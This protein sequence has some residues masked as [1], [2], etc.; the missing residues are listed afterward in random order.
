MRVNV[1]LI[2]DSSLK[3]IP[4]NRKLASAYLSGRM[5]GWFECRANKYQSLKYRDLFI[6]SIGSL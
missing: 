3:L 2:V 6:D 5:A 4:N 1:A